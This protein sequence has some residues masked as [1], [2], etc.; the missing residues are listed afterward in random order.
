[1]GAAFENKTFE[2]PPRIGI[3]DEDGYV[4]LT[5]EELD[6]LIGYLERVTQLITTNY[7]YLEDNY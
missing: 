1:M 5:R 4:R 6:S 3:V 7:T 2:P